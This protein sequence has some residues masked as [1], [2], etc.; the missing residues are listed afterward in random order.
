MA[1]HSARLGPEG[2]AAE[3][4]MTS[5]PDPIA[6]HF[7]AQGA[8]PRPGVLGRVVRL[9]LGL[10]L[11]SGVYSLSTTGTALIPG[12]EIPAHWTFWLYVAF[13]A[14]VT[15][16]VVNIGFGT[17]WR[18]RPQYAALAVVGLLLTVDLLI[19]GSWWAWPLGTFLWL[20]LMYVSI[21]LGG[22]F[23]VAAVIGTPGCEM[24]AFPHLWTVLSGRATREHVCPGFLDRVDRW[25]ASRRA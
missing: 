14:A 5:R 1:T 6:T 16:Y 21:H 17:N 20:W 13:V 18:R 2:A 19:W 11:A 7:E 3:I 23:L 10:G 24:R 12:T 15:P 8:L 22:S 9:G 25:E 4:S